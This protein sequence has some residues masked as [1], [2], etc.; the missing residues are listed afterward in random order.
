MVTVM[1]NDFKA[2]NNDDN[3]SRNENNNIN[4]Y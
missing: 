4:G 2:I 1:L 3:N